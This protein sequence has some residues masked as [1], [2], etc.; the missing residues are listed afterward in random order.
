MIMIHNRG[1]GGQVYVSGQIRLHESLI[2][3]QVSQVAV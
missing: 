1:E 3:V 2:Y